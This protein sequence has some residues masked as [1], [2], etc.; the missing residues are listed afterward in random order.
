M[1]NSLVEGKNGGVLFSENGSEWRLFDG[2]AQEIGSEAVMNWSEVRAAIVSEGLRVGKIVVGVPQKSDNHGSSVA[3]DESFWQSLSGLGPY[4][5]HLHLWQVTGQTL[6]PD[7]PD[8][9]EVLDLRGCKDLQKISRLPESLRT[10]D[11][12]DCPVVEKL[13][14]TV[15]A[16]LERFYFNGCERLEVDFFLGTL[17]RSGGA[18]VEVD[19]SGSPKVRSLSNFPR[20]LETL[21]LAGCRRLD[22]IETLGEF[23]NL[24]HLNFSECTAI[25]TLP[26]LPEELEYLV[27]FGASALH[28]FLNQNIGPYE[29]GRAGENVLDRLLVRKKYGT[30]LSIM[31][32]A[33]ILF[34]GNGRAGKTTLSKRMVWEQLD[35]AQRRSGENHRYKPTVKEDPTHG[36]RFSTVDI[37]LVLPEEAEK[38]LVACGAQSRLTTE[39]V[40]GV[41][42]TEDGR[43][44]G[45]VRIWDFGGQELYHRTHRIFASEGSIF[46]LLWRRDEPSLVDDKP[47]HVNELEWK[48]FNEQRSLDYWLEYVESIRPQSKVAIICSHCPDPDKMSDIPNWVKKAPRHADRAGKIST[49]F[50]DSLAD[51][52]GTHMT[53]QQLMDWICKM[54]GQVATDIGLVVPEFYQQISEMVRTLLSENEQQKNNNRA[55]CNLI[56]SWEDWAQRVRELW[57]PANGANNETND[58]GTAIND[59]DIEIITTYFHEAGHLFFI[60]GDGQRAV[61]IDQVWATSIIYKMLKPGSPLYRTIKKN[62]GWFLGGDLEAQEEWRGLKENLQGKQLWI[63]MQNCQLIGRLTRSVSKSVTESLFLISEKWLLPTLPEIKDRLDERIQLYKDNRENI[64]QENFDFESIIMNEFEFRGLQLF[65]G[66]H[67]GKNGIYYQDGLLAEENDQAPQWL[68][69]LTW[70]AD[71]ADGFSGKLTAFLWVQKSRQAEVTDMIYGILLSSGSPLENH[72]DRIHHRERSPEIHFPSENLVSANPGAFDVAISSSGVDTVEAEA[73]K[74]ALTEAGYRVNWYKIAA[75]RLDDRIGVENFMET[76]NHPPCIILLLSDRYL[77]IEDPG[78]SWYCGYELADALLRL[79]RGD[80]SVNQTLAVYKTL[81]KSDR[82]NPHALRSANLDSKIASLLET[83]ATYF[84]EKYAKIGSREK[85]QFQH[86]NDL[87]LKFAYALESD[88][89]TKF[90]NSRSDRGSYVE[91]PGDLS[92]PDAWLPLIEAVRNAIRK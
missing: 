28:S 73:M 34:L 43:L 17:H 59:H 40:L 79:G 1:E 90:V 15:P 19:G 23:R 54:C 71:E 75:C 58:S 48:A 25:K 92:A 38:D 62:G 9:L 10:L 72:R 76:L 7:L 18:L 78:G 84:S 51:E 20:S 85:R 33:K 56:F 74:T 24:K 50:V 30:R 13:P 86:Y 42:K 87:N 82:F 69:R 39:S 31:A 61:L 3:I 27:L 16:G 26:D 70:N 66:T 67:W 68:F 88:G 46:L 89:R 14:D 60:R 6:P 55:P 41:N 29:R 12:G 53:Y 77:N 64:C 36:I 83:R 52:C 2:T 35:E 5:T 91:V 47:E 57:M 81:P 80:R 22:D 49:F 11:L 4:L 45:T 44:R 32:H 37:G 65:L 8:S 21:V 63:F